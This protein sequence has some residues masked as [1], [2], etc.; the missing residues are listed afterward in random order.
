MRGLGI[1]IMLLLSSFFVKIWRVGDGV[2]FEG[3]FTIVHLFDIL[4][5]ISFIVNLS[6]RCFT[7]AKENPACFGP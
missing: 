5:L 3:T 4:A 6:N 1:N 2:K 7:Y